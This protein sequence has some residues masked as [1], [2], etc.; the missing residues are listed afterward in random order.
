M[1][2]Y[3][4]PRHRDEYGI[5]WLT[6]KKNCACPADWALHKN[7]PRRGDRGIT[8]TQSR[9]LFDY[10]STVVPVASCKYTREEL[11]KR[12]EGLDKRKIFLRTPNR[13]GPRRRLPKN[14]GGGMGPT[15]ISQLS[16]PGPQ[17]PLCGTALGTLGIHTFVLF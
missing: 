1:Y 8:L 3:I 6:N 12:G 13:D 4:C 7:S 11:P 17:N 16:A 10:T 15:T 9:L 5:H 14:S 2:L